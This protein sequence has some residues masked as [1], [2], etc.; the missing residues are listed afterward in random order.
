MGKAN[1]NPLQNEARFFPER[2]MSQLAH[3]RDYPLTLVEAPSGF[4]KTTAVR[5]FMR[6]SYPVDARRHWYTCL[7]EAPSRAWE[8]IC[9]LFAEADAEVASGLGDLYPPTAEA[10]PDIAAL[11]RACRCEAETVLVIDNFQL[12]ENETPRGIV[13]ALS[14]HAAE[15]LHVVVVTQPLPFARASIHNA[16]VLKLET[17][18]FFFDR[19][20]T[21]ELCH[22]SG[23]ETTRGELDYLQS[24]T[25][26]WVAALRLQM[27]NYRK[28]GSF[29]HVGDMDALI[30]TA[31]WNGISEGERDFLLSLSLLDGFTSRQAAFMADSAVLP[32]NLADL[33]EGNFFIPYVADKGVYA[34]HGILRAYLRKR[35]ENHPPDF[36]ERTTRLA[37]AACRTAGDYYQAARFF[38]EAS[39]FDAI[40]SLPLSTSYLN[41]RKEEG[42]VSFLERLVGECPEETLRRH[43]FALLAFAF[44]FMN[45]GRRELFARMLGLVQSHD[46]AGLFET[47]CARLQGETALLLSF[48]AFNDIA[49]M[50]AYHREAL[51]HL[52]SE[53]GSPQTAIFGTTPWTFGVSS[54]LHLFWREPGGLDEELSLMDECLPLYLKLTDG[55]GTGTDSVMRAEASLLRGDDASAEA[56]S[57][58]AIYLARDARQPSIYLCAELLLAHI[59]I[60]RGDDRA[61]ATVRGKIENH[62][63][64]ARDMRGMPHRAMHRMIE[65]CLARLD[66]LLERAEAL[67]D[68]LRDPE[69][70]RNT[71]YVQGH[72]YALTLHGRLLLL[73]GRHAELYGLTDPIMELARGMHYVLPQIDH[74]VHLAVAKSADGDRA[75]AGEYLNAALALALPDGAYLPFA[76]FGAA[77]L[78]LLEDAKVNFEAEKMDAL[79][80]LCARHARG[81]SA[82]V[83]AQAPETSILTPRERE[84]ALLAKERLGTR[85]IATRL[86][87]AEN[88]VK[89]ALRA[90]YG[91][92]EVHSKTE[93]ANIKFQ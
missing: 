69:A 50:S 40:L 46:P 23:I 36:A 1:G 2:L 91:K 41:E 65:L 54:V 60:L 32:R 29:A 14:V 7:G 75:A 59:A 90:I 17:R 33:L 82:V 78:P 42:V 62:A 6:R 79:T 81:V 85:E 3:I 83:R 38:F 57:H 52:G 16:N 87:I 11:T 12:F 15:N 9:R 26:G 35:F 49:K 76:E 37:A 21:A 19:D 70:I 88:T 22:L 80:A 53:A 44:Q 39:D 64:D 74:L 13:D 10:L 45:S 92:L 5:E 63:K 8:G 30:E 77:L 20:S 56:A 4:G 18:D 51:A 89:S 31:I 61:Y 72:P 86:C 68:W 67:P 43:P 28:T 27:E 47:E 24:V 34:M 73:E 25:E 58:K 55:H 71:L 48:T 66:L 93:L 84:I